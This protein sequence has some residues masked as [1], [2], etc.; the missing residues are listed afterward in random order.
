MLLIILRLRLIK[1]ELVKKSFDEL[2]KIYGG[3]ITIV[4]SLTNLGMPA[5]GYTEAVNRGWKTCGIAK[6]FKFFNVMK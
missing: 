3:N 5:L 2:K 4:S 6:H 1:L